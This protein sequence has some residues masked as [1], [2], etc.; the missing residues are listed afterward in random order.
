MTQATGIV[1]ILNETGPRDGRTP[2]RSIKVECSVP[3]CRY[4]A[5][6][7]V[8]ATFA[9]DESIIGRHL[10]QHAPDRALDIEVQWQVLAECSV[11]DDY[12][13]NV[14]VGGDGGLVCTVCGT[15]WDI[16]GKGG[17]RDEV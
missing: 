3:G 12:E 14:E 7:W 5:Y 1:T 16:D 10:S 4:C 11:C 9:N 17:Y 13:A 6:T 2:G 8:P 15:T